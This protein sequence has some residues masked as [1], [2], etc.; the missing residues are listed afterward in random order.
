MPMHMCVYY[1]HI[2]M[3]VF[4]CLLCQ[5]LFN[6]SLPVLLKGRSSH[7]ARHQTLTT[8][9]TSLLAETTHGASYTSVLHRSHQPLLPL[10]S[11][12]PLL[13]HAA[14]SRL[15][16]AG[17]SRPS[18]GRARRSRQHAPNGAASA[19]HAV[20]LSQRG[21]L[22]GA[23]ARLVPHPALAVHR[24]PPA[25]LAARRPA[26][27]A[28]VAGLHRVEAALLRAAPRHRLNCRLCRCACAACP[29]AQ[30]LAYLSRCWSRSLWFLVCRV[31][32]LCCVAM[33][34][35]VPDDDL[36][37]RPRVARSSGAKQT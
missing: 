30:M 14:R 11:A 13:R 35:G 4:L 9:S 5:C 2:C 6:K 36:W 32:L 20:L 17:G 19:Q 12:A 24:V 28:P 31:L 37:C 23:E 3:C 29:S 33:L 27:G 18:A 10:T 7:R 8:C 22:R 34:P 16:P 15:A 25:A 1:V 21:A 26:G